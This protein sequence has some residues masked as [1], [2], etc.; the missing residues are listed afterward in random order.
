MNFIFMF[1]DTMRAES[2][3][4]YGHPLKTTP[5][6]DAFAET[7]VRFEQCHTM[8]TQC[9]PS[10]ATMLTG[11]YM[12]V[13]GHRTQTNLLESYEQN[14]FQTLKKN[15]Y[16]IQYYGKNDVFSPDA[17][18]TSVSY[19]EGD[20]GTQSGSNAYEW[21]EAGYWSML[22]TGANVSKDSLTNKDYA[23][24]VKSVSFLKNQTADSPPFV[25]FLPGR[26]AHPPYGS[27]M[28]FH[29][30]WSVDEVRDSGRKLR[31]AFGP[32]KPRYHSRT[33]GVPFYRNL[34][35]LGAVDF[36]SIQKA[37]LGMVAYNDWIF[38]ELMK[39]LEES[40][41]ADST[42]VFY[43]SDHGDFAGDF[44]MIEKWPGGADDVLSRVPL[45]ARIPGGA[46]G[47]V[48]KA[49]VQLADVPHTICMLAGIDVVGDGSGQWGINFGHDLTPQLSAGHNEGDLSRFV[50]AEG[51]FKFYN[52]LFPGG[53]DHVPDDPKGMYWPRAQEEMS[54]NGTGSPKW[55][56]RRNLT[57]K[58]VYR[59]G[60]DSELYDYTVDPLELTNVWDVPAYAALQKE[61]LDGLLEWL[62]ET[63]DVTPVHTNKRGPPEYP[64]P[65][66]SCATSGVD[67]PTLEA[68]A[69][70]S[71]ASSDLLEAN[72]V[73][74]FYR[75]TPEFNVS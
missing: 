22:S 41:L 3:S 39:G 58:L 42:A 52:E 4:S 36:L 67:G 73:T 64:H 27:P 21:G 43:S 14:Y 18:N 57:H 59:P 32:T 5:N 54:G 44:E 40:G 61:L 72:G 48:S 60:F 9:S 26:G 16:W 45:Y 69:A 6:L 23:A 30:K 12:H 55:V 66:S 33:E 34:T 35:G 20:I 47:F 17:M 68:A 75:D 31:P 15:G 24:V 62:V 70:R 1:P 49:P 2:F 74:G 8:H 53:S 50:Y 11:R 10:R 29:N 51:G 71:V 13:L 25:L 37:Y 7:G 65:A 56:M 46:A 28:E 38:G 19:W 63:G